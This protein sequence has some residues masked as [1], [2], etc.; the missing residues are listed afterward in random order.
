MSSFAA[1]M[2]L[3]APLPMCKENEFLL[4]EGEPNP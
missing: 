4:V 3:T 2:L 1:V